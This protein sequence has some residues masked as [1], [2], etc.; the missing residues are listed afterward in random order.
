MKT[1]NIQYL[2]ILLA[3]IVMGFAFAKPEPPKATTNEAC[4][5]DEEG[6]PLIYVT[7]KDL[8]GNWLAETDVNGCFRLAEDVDKELVELSFPGYDNRELSLRTVSAEPVTLFRVKYLP[9]V[10]TPSGAVV[11]PTESRGEYEIKGQVLDASGEE[12]LI[13]VSILVDGTTTGT[14]TDIDGRFVLEVPSECVDLMISYTGYETLEESNVCGGKDYD[15][16]L[17]EGTPYE[18]VMHSGYSRRARSATDD[19]FRTIA[20]DDAAYYAEESVAAPASAPPPPLPPA[21]MSAKSVEHTTMGMVTELSMSTTADRIEPDYSATPSAEGVPSSGAIPGGA[22]ELPKAGQLTAGEVNDFSKWEMWSDI[23]Q[24]DLAMHRGTW[25]Q[26]ADHRYTLQLTTPDGSA[27][28]NAIATLKDGQGNA[29]WQARTDAQGRAELWAHY[30]R[31]V[32]TPANGLIIEVEYAGKRLSITNAKPFKEGINFQTLGVSCREDAVVDVAFVVDATGSMGDEIN[33]LQAELLDVIGRVREG[34]PGVDLQMGSV[35]YR[36]KGEQYLTRVQ[37]F[38]N[39]AEEAMK[40]MEQQQ[41]QGGGDYPEAVEAALESALDSLSWRDDA[42]TRLLFLVLDAPPHQADENIKRM[43]VAV[44]KAA[45]QGIQI[46]PVSCSGVDKSTEY[47]LR[48]M[49]L[50]TNGTYTFVT[51][52]SGIGNAHIEPSTDSYEVEYLNDV[53]ARLTIERSQLATCNPPV[54]EVELPEPVTPAE[55][56]WEYY[57]NPTSGPLSLR[58]PDTDGTLYL[59]D[60]HGKLLLQ[61]PANEEFDMNLGTYPAGTYWLRH[62]STEG[63]WT[64]GQVLLLRR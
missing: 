53:L 40:F 21:P 58:F 37:S 35:F 62:Q 57:P 12:P 42:S 59:A 16:Q 39:K 31:E 46:I 10:R 6:N 23:S 4:V 11:H 20:V 2:L 28:V 50:A 41:A 60:A 26:Y 9:A 27:V 55:R 56:N 19:V 18:E 34:L 8:E 49:A 64:Q 29:L 24:E 43:Q 33:Y 7:V 45:M 25:Q 3:T 36:D 14:L 54:A 52:H 32:R 22:P 44:T 47:L 51:D 5:V 38:T 63:E 1:R 15:F 17:E 30:F 48:S 61:R 13:G